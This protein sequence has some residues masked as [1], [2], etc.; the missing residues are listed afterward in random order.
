MRNLLLVGTGGFLGSVFRYLLGGA[1]TQIAANSRLPVGTL[2]VNVVGCLVI[3]MLAAFGEQLRPWSEG[4]RFFLFTGVLGGF[5]TFSA[6]GY[7]TFMVA[8]QQTLALAGINVLLQ[9]GL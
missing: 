6:F 9:V 3:G 4:A 2:V 7:E 1:A 8:R 5:T